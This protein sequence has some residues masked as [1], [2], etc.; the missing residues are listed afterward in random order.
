ML[1]C[2]KYANVIFYEV[3]VLLS[4]QKW[5]YFWLEAELILVSFSEVS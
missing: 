4:Q 5:P 1:I 3:V 2:T